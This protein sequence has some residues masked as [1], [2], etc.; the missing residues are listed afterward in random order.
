MAENSGISIHSKNP[1]ILKSL[2]ADGGPEGADGIKRDVVVAVD[3]HAQR[4][5]HHGELDFV[6]EAFTVKVGLQYDDDGRRQCF[7]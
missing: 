2:Y 1:F 6:A 4:D 7:R 3:E 5:W